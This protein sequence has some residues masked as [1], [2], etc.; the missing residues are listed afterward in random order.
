M[1]TLFDYNNTFIFAGYKMT[2]K[3]AISQIKSHCL[4]INNRK[5][6]NR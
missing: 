2:I 6:T 3:I 4:A 1:T 5:I